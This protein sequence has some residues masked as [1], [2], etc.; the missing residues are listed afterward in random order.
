MAIIVSEERGT[1]SIVE[2]GRLTPTANANELRERIQEIFQVVP[3]P[4]ESLAPAEEGA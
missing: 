2:N 4:R 3:E 1:V